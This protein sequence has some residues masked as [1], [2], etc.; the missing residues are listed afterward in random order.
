MSKP[1]NQA[2][3]DNPNKTFLALVGGTGLIG[4][5][6]FGLAFLL[7]TPLAEQITITGE[8]I[9]LG[10]I[11]TTP[12]ALFLL[13]FMRTR[14]SYLAA[15]RQSQVE[16]FA[17]IGFEFTWPRIVMMALAAGVCEEL[18]FRG[19]FQSFAD[20]F[21]PTVV[22][23]LLTN[24]IFG[25]L[26]W[27]TA[28]YAMIAGLVGVYLGWLYWFS[29]SLVTPMITHALYDFIA[30]WFTRDAIKAYKAKVKTP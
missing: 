2:T 29:N 22:A 30:L 28:L 11:A 13:W 27:R 17:S 16:F 12:L 1:E 15:F 26:H 20:R 25:A 8:T 24:V 3:Q 21:M 7:N 18:L 4:I 19:V 14:N 6:A 10:I 9:A 5:A 23:I